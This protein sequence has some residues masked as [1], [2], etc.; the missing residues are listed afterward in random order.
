MSARRFKDVNTQSTLFRKKGH[1]LVE[2]KIHLANDIVLFMS[3]E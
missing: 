3:T 2:Q 1:T